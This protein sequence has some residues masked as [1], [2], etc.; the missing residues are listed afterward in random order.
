MSS[1][2]VSA[3]MQESTLFTKQANATNLFHLLLRSLADVTCY[4]TPRTRRRCYEVR[5]Q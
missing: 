4:V 1:R 2:M 3:L 5:I